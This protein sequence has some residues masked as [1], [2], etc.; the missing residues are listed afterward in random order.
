MGCVVPLL[1]PVWSTLGQSV[2]NAVVMWLRAFVSIVPACPMGI[3]T[4]LTL[5]QYCLRA[6]TR[7]EFFSFFSAC[8][9]SH[10]KSRENP[11]SMRMRVH[12]FLLK[13]AWPGSGVSGTPLAYMRSGVVPWPPSWIIIIG[14]N[15][16]VT[17]Y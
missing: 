9:L 16:P 10:S 3:A 14:Y 12:D 15:T 13:L 7:G 17:A 8:F 2:E 6:A 5:P 4:N 1:A 11:I